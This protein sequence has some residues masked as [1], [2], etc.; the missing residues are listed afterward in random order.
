MVSIMTPNCPRMTEVQLSF[1]TF[2]LLERPDW[3]CR[4]STLL[5]FVVSSGVYDWHPSWT[6]V[7]VDGQSM[8]FNSDECWPRSSRYLLRR[9]HRD[10][11]WCQWVCTVHL[12]QPSALYWVNKPSLGHFPS[13]APLFASASSSGSHLDFLIFDKQRLWVWFFVQGIIITDRGSLALPL[14]FNLAL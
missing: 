4:C 6:L 14:A 7:G 12:K 2:F 13:G 1:L 11:Q 5:A 8:H 9:R 3:D 10:G